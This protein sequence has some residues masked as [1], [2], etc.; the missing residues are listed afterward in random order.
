MS[1]SNLFNSGFTTRNQN[2]FASIVKIALSD[3]ALNQEEKA[4]LDRLAHHLNLSKETYDR[5]LK[6]YK[7][8]PINPSVSQNQRLECLYD[9]SRMV[10]ADDIKKSSE[11]SMLNKI[12]IGLG[13]QT[14]VVPELVH[15]SLTL[16]K[17][18][19]DF[20]TFKKE[21]IETFYTK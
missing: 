17:K 15:T 6:N 8:H 5:I 7:S 1:F 4:F 11:V 20:E 13:F 16:V 2:H 21:I 10:Y 18:K 12:A 9:L 3:D 19:V 14:T